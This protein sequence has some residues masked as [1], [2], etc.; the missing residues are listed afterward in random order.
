MLPIYRDQILGVLR[1]VLTIGA[2]M[3]VTNGYLTTGLV[4][5]ELIAGAAVA[6]LTIGMSA[7]QK[8]TA[9][10]VLVVALASK[11]PV[12]ETQVTSKIALGLPI[13][14]VLTPPDV[15]PV[16]VRLHG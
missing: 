12:S 4:S 16:P 14:S 9:R 10:Q 11:T 7:Y 8:F 15:V 13:P 1:H 6:L 2:G 3:L 5:P